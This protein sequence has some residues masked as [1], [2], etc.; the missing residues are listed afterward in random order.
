MESQGVQWATTANQ[1][2]AQL[3]AIV[4]ELR[5]QVQELRQS[6]SS[7]ARQVLPEPNHFDGRSKDWDTWLMTMRAKLK[8]DGDAIGGSEA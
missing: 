8:I 1:R 7:K 5:T 6:R 3:L 2:E 4:D